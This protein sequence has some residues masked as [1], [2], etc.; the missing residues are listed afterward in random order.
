VIALLEA[1]R[2]EKNKEL[3]RKQRLKGNY[4]NFEKRKFGRLFNPEIISF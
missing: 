2:A 4:T 1:G 3:N